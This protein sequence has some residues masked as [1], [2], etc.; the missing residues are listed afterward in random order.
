MKVNNRDEKALVIKN[1]PI[2]GGAVA[3]EHHI[4]RLLFKNRFWK[5]RSNKQTK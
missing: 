3:S 2:Q 1:E 5:K 4:S